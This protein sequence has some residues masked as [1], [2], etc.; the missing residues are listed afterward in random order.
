MRAWNY[1]ISFIC[2]CFLLAA[3]MT[4]VGLV[5][6]WDVINTVTKIYGLGWLIIDL[7]LCW[8]TFALIERGDNE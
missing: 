1:F 6:S 7:L 5:N 4:S 2:C 3:I 8:G